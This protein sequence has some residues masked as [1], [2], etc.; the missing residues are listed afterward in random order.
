MTPRIVVLAFLF[1]ACGG[2]EF[3]R[4]DAFGTA[5]EE[6]DAG[7][8]PAP[9]NDTTGGAVPIMPLGTV[10]AG[11]S[12]VPPAASPPSATVPDAAAPATPP[13]PPGPE[14]APAVTPP[15]KPDPAPTPPAPPPA[16][17]DAGPPPAPLPDLTCG[18]G[19]V[20]GDTCGFYCLVAT[21]SDP[22]ISAVSYYGGS[23]PECGCH[24]TCD[25]LIIQHGCASIQGLTPG[26][27]ISCTSRLDGVSDLR[28]DYARK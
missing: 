26:R 15:A 10:N 18:G 20:P 17:P 14:P 19:W 24:P 16:K 5:P 9:S 7:A 21:S 27:M 3:M 6:L 8:A 11:K 2:A 1:S 22:R 28:C 25:C 12:T 4:L 13:A 23:A